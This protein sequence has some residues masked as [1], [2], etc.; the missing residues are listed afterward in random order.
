MTTAQ[1]A[2]RC[3]HGSCLFSSMTASVETALPIS[4]LKNQGKE[5][6]DVVYP[7]KYDDYEITVD[8]DMPKG[9][10]LIEML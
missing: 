7:S 5:K 1:H 2:G 6:D 8:C 4:C 3:A 9:V 10:E